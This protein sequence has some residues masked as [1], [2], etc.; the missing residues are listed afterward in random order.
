MCVSPDT[1]RYLLC[2]LLSLSFINPVFVFRNHPYHIVSRC[3]YWHFH[4][5]PPPHH[6]QSIK[7]SRTSLL[8]V[9]CL[10][11]TF[12]PSSRSF[13]HIVEVQSSYCCQVH[14]GQPSS[15]NTLIVGQSSYCCQVDRGQPSSANTLIVGQ[16]S[17]CCQVDFGQPSLANSHRWSVILLLPS[18]SWSAF[19]SQ[20]SRCWSA[21]LLLPSTLLV[22]LL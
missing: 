12:G 19:F 8:L 10:A 17:H 16:P 2:P 14:C 20:H 4:H 15:A 5:C 3:D 7:E 13:Q 6:S 1:V 21:I 11:G 9:P 22:S 18:R